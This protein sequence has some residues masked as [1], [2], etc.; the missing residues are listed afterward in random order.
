MHG[1][2]LLVLAGCIACATQPVPAQVSFDAVKGKEWRLNEIRAGGRLLV[3]DR[4][5]LENEG[6]AGVFTLIFEDQQVHGRG[7]PNTFRAPY[8]QAQNQ[9]LSIGNAAATLMAPL[10]EPEDFKEREY[11][12]CLGNTYHWNLVQGN[13]ELYTKTVDGKDA[14]LVFI[15]R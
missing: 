4:Q 7:A 3:L 5:K 15:A 10:K 13:L 14:T 1:L 2:Y 6:F 12:T 8:E 9:S 11:F